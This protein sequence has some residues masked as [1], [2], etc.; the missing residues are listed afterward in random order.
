MFSASVLEHMSVDHFF[1][2]LLLLLLAGLVDSGPRADFGHDLAPQFFGQPVHVLCVH[3]HLVCT[4]RRIRQVPSNY[5]IIGTKTKKNW[6]LLQVQQ[7]QTVLTDDFDVELGDGQ[8]QRVGLRDVRDAVKRHQ[9][10][11]QPA[12][13]TWQQ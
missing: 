9:D 10:R 12:A 3:Q 5:G 4:Y 8:D 13:A 1:A 2:Y 7:R 11:D 6:L